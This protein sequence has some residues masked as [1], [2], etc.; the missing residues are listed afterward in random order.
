MAHSLARGR[1]SMGIQD[2]EAAT[3][4]TFNDM[5]C[6]QAASHSTALEF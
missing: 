4:E 2:L 6:K 1:L 3:H 5:R